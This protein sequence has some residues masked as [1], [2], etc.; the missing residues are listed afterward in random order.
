MSNINDLLDMF[1]DELSEE[2]ILSE[3]NNNNIANFIIKYRLD[4][5]LSK[6][7]MAKL[8]DISYYKYMKIENE[9]YDFK[10]SEIVSI[11]GKLGYKIVF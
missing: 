5:N 10:V 6:K 1:C 9:Y 8:L 4:N 7:D 11:C 2:E 3:I